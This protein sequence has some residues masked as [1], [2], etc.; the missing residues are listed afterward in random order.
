[1]FLILQKNCPIFEIFQI[2]H[3]LVCYKTNYFKIKKQMI[4]SCGSLLKNRVTLDMNNSYK[5]R[6]LIDFCE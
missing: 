5:L 4:I 6:L 2:S 1:M 3:V